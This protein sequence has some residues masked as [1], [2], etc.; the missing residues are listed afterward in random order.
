MVAGISLLLRL[1]QAYA[2][3]CSFPFTCH[4]LHP[5]MM[6]VNTGCMYSS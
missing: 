6:Y 5:V 3:S 2:A 1:A 4:I